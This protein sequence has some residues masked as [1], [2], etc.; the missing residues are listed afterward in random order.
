MSERFCSLIILGP[1]A[2][3]TFKLH[4]SRGAVT[5]LVLAF[6]LSF[7]AVI[8]LGSSYPG[9]VSDVRRAQLQEEN[10]ALKLETANAVIGIR[11]LSAKV[12]AME[13]T[14]KRIEGLVVPASY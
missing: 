1:G 9:S 5:I 6:L 4:L 14:S 11:K 2:P 7:L 12:E 8:W 3:S 13:E 10:R